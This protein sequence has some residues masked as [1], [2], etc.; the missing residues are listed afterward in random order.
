MAQDRRPLGIYVGATRQNDGKTTMSMGL[1]NA[2]GEVEPSIGYIKPVGQQV[3]LVDGHQ[4]DKD[5]TLMNDLFHIGNHLQ[6]MS[7]VA[8]PR[9]FTEDFISGKNDGSLPEKIREAYRREGEG[10]ELM[11]IEGTG[12]AGVG[13]VIELSNADVAALLDVPVVIVTCGGIGKPI[14]EV[15]LNKALF[16]S[17]GV[18]VLGVIVN[19]VH[20]DKYEKIDTFVRMGFERKGIPVLGVLPF[21]PGLSSPTMRQLLEDM[22][23][24]LLSGGECLDHSVD[25]ILVGAMPPRAAKTLPDNGRERRRT[26]G[27]LT[28]K[29]IPRERD[30]NHE[31]SEPWRNMPSGH[32]PPPL[33]DQPQALFMRT[34]H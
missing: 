20:Q 26:Q 4:I 2:L 24:D 8:I 13:S 33:T 27:L 6:D 11:V 16:D 10:K 9:G 34:G 19:K 23:A 5:A 32:P 30:R 18:K 28:R 17:R 3:K 12:H 22:G 25:R 7:P 29:H 1:L 21:F 31:Q 15:S 14:D